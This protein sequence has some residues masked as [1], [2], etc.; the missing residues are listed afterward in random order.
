MPLLH[1]AA[2]VIV[3][4]TH[5]TR[6]YFLD[7]RERRAPSGLHGGERY[8]ELDGQFLVGSSCQGRQ[9]QVLI[10][11]PEAEHW[12]MKPENNI[13]KGRRRGGFH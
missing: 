13:A 2:I 4:V 6:H 9:E 5:Q 11:I 8:S 10:G 12:L 1:T 3:D 7:P